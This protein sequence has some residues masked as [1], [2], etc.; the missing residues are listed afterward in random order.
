MKNDGELWMTPWK[1]KYW[2][3]LTNEQRQK[4]MDYDKTISAVDIE[5]YE[6]AVK[7]IE[8]K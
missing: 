7:E 6:N 5:I 2:K 8:K 1:A 3:N 4:L